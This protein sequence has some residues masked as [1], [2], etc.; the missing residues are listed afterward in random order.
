MITLPVLFPYLLL[1]PEDTCADLAARQ[2]ITRR[3]G[4]KPDQF[5]GFEVQAQP[6]SLYKLLWP[7][8]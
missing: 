1:V 6:F 7:Y 5:R 2:L 8:S 3:D 4:V